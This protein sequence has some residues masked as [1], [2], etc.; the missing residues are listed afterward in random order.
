[1]NRKSN[2]G[3]F[4]VITNII[5]L[6]ISKCFFSSVRL[7]RLPFYIRGKKYIDFGKQITLGRYC[8]FDVLGTHESKILSF[9]DNVVV[10][11]NVRISCIEKIRIGKNVLIGS[12]VLIIDNAHGKYDGQDADTPYTP[13]NL[14]TL[15][16]EPIEVGDNV[17]I[18]EGAVIQKGV[19]IGS[20]CVI[21][22]NT[23]VTK[24][25]PKN[26]IVAGLPGRIIKQ[27]NSEKNKWEAVN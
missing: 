21:A 12:R 14:R 13:P 24:D 11:D 17:W 26:S 19:R 27:F 18:G 16:S 23:V 20:G 1:M 25:V 8:R 9:G 4:E 5:D 3:I 2:Y 6:L 10:G 15:Q 7:I 22:A